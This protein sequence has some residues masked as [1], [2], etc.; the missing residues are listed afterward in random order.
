M[1][2][3]K[4]LN[5]CVDCN[6]KNVQEKKIRCLVVFCESITGDFQKMPQIETQKEKF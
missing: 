1:K 2:L 4:F 5:G 6:V 3:V